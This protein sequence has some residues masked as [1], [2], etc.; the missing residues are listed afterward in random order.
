MLDL[1]TDKGRLVSA[2]LGL[3]AE[4]PWAQVTLADIA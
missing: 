1:T 2:A 4:K 3:A